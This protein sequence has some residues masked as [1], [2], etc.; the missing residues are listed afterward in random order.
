MENSAQILLRERMIFRQRQ[1]ERERKIKLKKMVNIPDAQITIR[2]MCFARIT[3][4]KLTTPA[5]DLHS[6]Q[7]E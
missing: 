6:E 7:N 5:E 3:F 2:F 1:R 4:Y